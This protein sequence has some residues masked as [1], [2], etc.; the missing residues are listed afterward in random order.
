MLPKYYIVC[1]LVPSTPT[2]AFV[3]DVTTESIALHWKAGIGR[4]AYFIV[5]Q[6]SG[7]TKWNSTNLQTEHNV[8]SLEPGTRYCFIITAYIGEQQSAGLHLCNYSRE[9]FHLAFIQH[10][11]MYQNVSMHEFYIKMHNRMCAYN[12][13]RSFAFSVMNI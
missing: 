3:Q 8:T 10:C 7:N 5:S 11:N 1:I 6:D 2:N 9:Q 4:A 13:P 12:T